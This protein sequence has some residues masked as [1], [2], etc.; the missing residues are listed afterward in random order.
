VSP[1]STDAKSDARA[2]RRAEALRGR[3]A[4]RIV[5]ALDADQEQARRAAALQLVEQDRLLGRRR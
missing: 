4:R 5:A 2:Q 3:A 1:L